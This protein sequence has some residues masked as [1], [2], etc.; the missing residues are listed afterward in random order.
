MLGRSAFSAVIAM[1][2]PTIAIAQEQFIC[3]GEK[4]T[5]FKWNGKD[6]AIANFTVNDDKFL[7]Q[8]V[9]PRELLG[10]TFTFEV[11]RFGRNDIHFQCE[12]YKTPTYTSTRIICGGLGYGMLIDT[13]SLRFQEIYSMGY[14]D[15]KDDDA[16]T[17]SITIGTCSRIK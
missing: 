12:R 6:W 4:A 9:S 5:G 15:G 13:Q 10:K 1:T 3:L 7:V 11:K 14:I 16:N 8:E 17:P 2:A